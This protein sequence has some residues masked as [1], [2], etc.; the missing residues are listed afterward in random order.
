MIGLARGGPGKGLARR[1]AGQPPGAVLPEIAVQIA[2]HVRSK[3]A[4]M[5]LFC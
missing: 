2:P 5:L 4:V 3:G 1:I